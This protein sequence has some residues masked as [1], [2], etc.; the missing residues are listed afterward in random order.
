METLTARTW[1]RESAS[2]CDVPVTPFALP[3]APCLTSQQHYTGPGGG[4]FT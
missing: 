2:L 1:S 4:L 3:H